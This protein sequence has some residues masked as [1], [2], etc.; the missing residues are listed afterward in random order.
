VAGI[1][2]EARCARPAKRSNRDAA[3]E[4]TDDAADAAC[5]EVIRHDCR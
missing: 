3:V 2:H 5:P 4:N 1:E